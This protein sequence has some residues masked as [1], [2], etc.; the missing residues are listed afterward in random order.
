ERLGGG[1]RGQ[2]DEAVERDPLLHHAEVVHQAEAV[3]DARGAV[4][5]LAEVTQAE[6][7][8]GILRKSPRPSSFCPFIQNG[9]WSVATLAR[10]PSSRHLHRTSWFHFSRRAGVMTHFG[11]SYPGRS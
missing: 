11:P 8:N 4:G 7:P 9:Q 6:I 3:L 10:C 1:G 2:L 5:D